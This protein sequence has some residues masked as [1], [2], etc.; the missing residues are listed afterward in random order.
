MKAHPYIWIGGSLAAITVVAYSILSC[1]SSQKMKAADEEAQAKYVDKG[2]DK[3][4]AN[5]NVKN[6]DAQSVEL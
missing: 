5:Q 2:S 3:A 6:A 1:R 4:S